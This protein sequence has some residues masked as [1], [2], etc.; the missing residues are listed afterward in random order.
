MA[1][2]TD[3][4]LAAALEQLHQDERLTAELTDA[5]AEAVLAWLEDELRSARD[6][7]DMQFDARLAILRRGVKQAAREFA[8][9]PHGLIAAA[10]TNADAPAA[11]AAGIVGHPVPSAPGPSPIA[12][13]T[14]V[15]G[16][17]EPEVRRGWRK[18]VFRSRRRKRR[19][20]SS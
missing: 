2:Q 5:D 4:R 20:W 19:G 14:A 15:A 18:L 3:Q 9:D 10:K 8:G 11:V 13:N 12:T 6:L 1:E 17:V 16:P 7:N